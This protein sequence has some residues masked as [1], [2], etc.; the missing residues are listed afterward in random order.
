M[1]R[2]AHRAYEGTPVSVSKSRSSIDNILLKWGVIGV[3]W[4]DDYENGVAQL[5]FRWKRADDSVLVAR[6]RIE[7]DS[8][9]SLN[10]K[11]RDGRSG[12]FS[13]KKYARLKMDR[14]KREHRVL[15]NFLKSMFE[16]IEQG[17]IPAEALLL[18]WLEDVD[19]K[20]VHDKL[21]PRIGVLS[22]I[23]FHKALTEGDIEE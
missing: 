20:T 21:A 1:V 6:F 3:Q 23:P 14:G 9:E 7:V 16:A 17:I 11:A 19:G 2:T 12:M 13:A 10:E 18:A 5:R 4:D 8:E 22:S 15:F